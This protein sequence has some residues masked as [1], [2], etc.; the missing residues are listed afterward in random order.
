MPCPGDII[1][2]SNTGDIIE[3]CG[4]VEYIDG[5][6]VIS[7]DG[8]ATDPGGHFLLEQGGAVSRRRRIMS[9]DRIVGYGSMKGEQNHGN[10]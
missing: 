9:N 10:K 5:D 7:I 4:I 6:T 8:N 3:H 2:L 1:F